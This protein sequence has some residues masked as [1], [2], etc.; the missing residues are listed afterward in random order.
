MWGISVWLRWCK[1]NGMLNS[2]GKGNGR[3][4]MAD[5]GVGRLALTAFRDVMRK[6]QSKF[7]KVIEWLD[8]RIEGLRG[9]EGETCQ[10][11]KGIV[12]GSGLN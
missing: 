8:E 7:G 11:M 3:E 4:L 9:R 2:W 5:N 6:R 12:A 1:S 10:R